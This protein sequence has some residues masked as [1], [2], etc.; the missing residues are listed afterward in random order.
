MV[1]LQVGELVLDGEIRARGES[2][3]DSGAGGAGGS[4][5]VRA[6]LLH[7]A[8]LIDASGGDHKSQ[9]QDGGGGGGRVA[10]YVGDATGF[11]PLAQVRAWGGSRA[12]DSGPVLAYAAPGTILVKTG[13]QTYG[14]LILDAGQAAGV[15]RNGPATELPAL[16]AGALAGLETAGADAWLTGAAPFGTPWAGAWV[17]LRD[18]ASAEL[19]LFRVLRIDAQG[20]ALL[21][22]AGA[23]SETGGAASYRGE[24]RFDAVETRHGAGLV[25]HDPVTGSAVS[26][27]NDTPVHRR[28]AGDRRHRARRRRGPPAGGPLC[29]ASWSAAS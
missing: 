10:L 22:G 20:R 6:G 13:S 19:G 3:L 16:G 2:R 14:R 17:R 18:A 7:G 4:V 27:Q 8:G 23:V 15:D 21:A 26:F 11:D 9:W 29:C 25:A 5:L 12:L 28:A 24:Y 1:D